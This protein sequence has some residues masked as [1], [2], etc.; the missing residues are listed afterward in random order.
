MGGW[1][2]QVRSWQEGT[3]PGRTENRIL[4]GEFEGL[5]DE[6]LDSQQLHSTGQFTEP[7]HIILEPLTNHQ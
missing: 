2:R 5:L 6:G 3:E 7:C 4:W 1:W